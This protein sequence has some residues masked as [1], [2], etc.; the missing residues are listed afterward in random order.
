MGK[1][2]LICSE[3]ELKKGL[4]YHKKIE[5]RKGSYFQSPFFLKLSHQ[6]VNFLSFNVLV[7][8]KFLLK[9]DL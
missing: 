3:L 4:S 5:S 9:I 1:A 8:K 6:I 2:V 7:Y